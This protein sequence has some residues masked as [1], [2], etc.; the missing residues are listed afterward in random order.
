MSFSQNF[1]NI[2]GSSL[3]QPSDEKGVL[4]ECFFGE[5]ESSQHHVCNYPKFVLLQ[6]VVQNLL[7]LQIYAQTWSEN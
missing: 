6:T 7:S 1:Q 2:P 5:N 3:N 4:G